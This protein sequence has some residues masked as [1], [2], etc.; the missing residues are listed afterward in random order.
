MTGFTIAALAAR[1]QKIDSSVQWKNY[2]ALACLGQVKGTKKST[3][4]TS[5]FGKDKP[6]KDFNNAWSRAKHLFHQ[7]TTDHKVLIAESGIDEAVTLMSTILANHM[8]ALDVG[9]RTAY[10]L[11]C[12][13]ASKADIPATEPEA[14]AEEPEAIAEVPSTEEV[15][16]GAPAEL[17]DVFSSACRLIDGMTMDEMNLLAVYLTERMMALQ[18]TKIAA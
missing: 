5:V 14:P 6:T 15:E 1:I 9:G 18:E 17:P 4:E 7:V 2:T 10:D 12:Q 16:T 13:Y 8:T 3:L 11:V